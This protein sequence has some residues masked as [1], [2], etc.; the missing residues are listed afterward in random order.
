VAV[1][2]MRPIAAQSKASR[3]PWPW[4]SLSLSAPLQSTPSRCSSCVP[5][6][7][8]CDSANACPQMA[9]LQRIAMW[10][11]AL[12]QGSAGGVGVGLALTEAGLGSRKRRV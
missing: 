8:V 1:A 11:G 3:S 4:S 7:G 6:Q 10:W 9:E 12:Q 2:R 5:W